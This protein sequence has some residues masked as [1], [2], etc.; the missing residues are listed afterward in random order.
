MKKTI[1][2]F[3]LLF[4]LSAFAQNISNPTTEKGIITRAI[5]LNGD[6]LPMFF[7][8]EVYIFSKNIRSRSQAIE[9]TRLVRNVKKVL[10]YAK[11]AG[12]KI[13]N[14]N[15]KLRPINSRRERDRMVR[16]FQDALFAEFEGELRNLTISQGRILVK[17]IDRETGNPTYDIINNYRGSFIAG[18]WQVTGRIFGYNLKEQYDPEGKDKEIEIIVRMI[19]SGAL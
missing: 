7:L 1:I 2:F 3:L 10:P 13:N 19:E 17:L 16:R 5:I 11:I 8:P 15:E 9:W 14:Y 6:T 18:F 12:E 4:S